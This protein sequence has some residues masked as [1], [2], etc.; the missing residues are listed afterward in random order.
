MRKEVIGM[1]E[2][3]EAVVDEVRDAAPV[4]KVAK[5]RYPERLRQFVH[6]QLASAAIV[7]L[8]VAVYTAV[9]NIL[10]VVDGYP[11]F[12]YPVAGG[13]VCIVLAVVLPILCRVLGGEWNIMHFLAP[14]VFGACFF[15]DVLGSLALA[16]VNNQPGYA[17]DITFFPTFGGFVA[18]AV[19]PVVDG[20]GGKIT[21]AYVAMPT[22]VVALAMLVLLVVIP[23]LMLTKYE[24]DS[25]EEIRALFCVKVAYMA[26]FAVMILTN[27]IR[28]LV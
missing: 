25:R 14:G 2:S 16:F 8:A 4:K 7:C 23:S 18:Q 5:S 26:L 11:S 3:K 1:N 22:L 17:P 21:F 12:E 15:F 19:Y 24:R 27:V 6:P 28:F 9:Y 10:I 20:V 13:I